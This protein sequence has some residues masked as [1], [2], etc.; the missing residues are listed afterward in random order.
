MQPNGRSR[1][2][3]SELCT[4][5]GVEQKQAMNPGTVLTQLSRVDRVRP[6]QGAGISKA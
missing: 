4:I 1:A 3:M 6:Q 2:A 5:D